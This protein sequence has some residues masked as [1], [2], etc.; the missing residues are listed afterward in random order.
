MLHQL[1]AMLIAV[2]AESEGEKLK[3][4]CFVQAFEICQQ[5]L[6][7][8]NKEAKKEVT[9]GSYVCR[10]FCP[11]LISIINLLLPP[12]MFPIAAACVLH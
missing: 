10:L 9:G 2:F 11:C 5:K 12:L 1:G 6:Q 4:K 3:E 8:I 7:A